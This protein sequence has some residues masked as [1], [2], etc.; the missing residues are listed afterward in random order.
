MITNEKPCDRLGPPWQRTEL[1]RRTALKAGT[2]G[3]AASMMFGRHMAF[4]AQEGTPDD[5]GPIL[6]LPLYPY[7]Q[8][9]TLDPHRAINWGSHWVLLPHVWAGLLRFDEQGAVIPDLATSIEPEQDGVVWVATLRSDVVFAS[10]NPV[11]AEAM[12]LGWLRAL[13]PQQ[14]S[15][16]ARF[17]SR[18]EGYDA[19]VA[20]ES[21]EIGFEA[22]DE[23]T[24]AIRLSEPYVHFPE[25][26]AAFVWAAV[27]V[28][29][30]EG[31]PGSDVPFANASAG[32]WQ[33]AASDDASVIRMIPNPETSNGRPADIAEIHW[34]IMTG[35]LAT[36]TAFDLYENGELAIADLTGPLRQQVQQD[37][38]LS[39]QVRTIT[40]SGSTMLIGMDFARAP[41]D[42]PRVRQAVAMSIDRTVWAS[43][44]MQGDFTEATS[45][46]PPVLTE[47]ANYDAPEPLPFDPDQARALLAEAGIDESNLPAV[48]YYQPADAPQMEIEQAEALLSMIEENSGL[49]IEHDLTL[50]AEQIQA[51]RL[52]NGG[53]QFAIRWWWPLTNSPSGL[54]DLAGPASDDMLGWFNWSPDLV[55]DSAADAAE[56]YAALIEEASVTLDAT[57]RI[58][59]YAEAEQLL[60]DNAVFVPLGHWIQTYLQSPALT[61]TRQGTFTGY[62]PL[63]FDD[64]VEYQPG[65]G[66]PTA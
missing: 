15:P 34:Q 12:I 31:V 3:A 20:G 51:L 63:V 16:M 11:T 48:V 21:E 5:S 57:E 52:D 14:L 66:T 25:D 18:V 7:G 59:L 4:A 26:L 1:S 64:Q 30:L 49:I 2:A 53:L 8:P 17:M 13:D 47:T 45:I 24:I 9:V 39:E 40:P 44:V 37:Q 27:D 55:N 19:F 42:D 50:T 10:G 41:F 6:S 23:M 54:A 38:T 65:A 58:Q 28:A 32:L 43:E 29:A 60:V 62:A 33:F 22:R 61:G 36:E 56:S 35:G 46:T